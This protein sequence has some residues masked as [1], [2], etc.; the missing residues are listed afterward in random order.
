MTSQPSKAEAKRAFLIEQATLCL[1]QH[2]YAHVS[3]R[4]IAKAS[5]VSLG[6]LHYY[7][8]SKED[9]LLAVISSYKDSFIQE[10]ETALAADPLE[11][12]LDRLLEVLHVALTEKRAIHRLW[13][14]L[15]VQGMYVPAFR[16]QVGQI[17]SRMHD[18][19]ARMLE[20]LIHQKTHR[21][22][23]GLDEAVSLLYAQV[24]G[25]FFQA[26]L[27]ETTSTEDTLARFEQTLNQLLNLI[28]SIPK[29][30]GES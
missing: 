2:G 9:L 5:G 11:G 8:A 29:K 28:F 30:R 3:L 24:D 10:M 23:I 26:M 19:I 12:W 1:A 20:R 17:R 25:L 21:L 6:I 16:E 15:Q 27:E 13:Y 22:Q 14:D 18:L 4:D 7:F